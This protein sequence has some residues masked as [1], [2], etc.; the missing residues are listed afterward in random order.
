MQAD[1]YFL[2]LLRYP[3][4]DSK[5]RAMILEGELALP[6]VNWK[7]YFSWKASFEEAE[8]FLQ[9]A[10]GLYVHMFLKSSGDLLTDL[11][12]LHLRRYFGVS[13]NPA[14]R[15]GSTNGCRF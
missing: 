2:R 13:L 6:A 11:P 5:T 9:R 14:D 15:N 12:E 1:V 8:G 4:G 10:L 7:A 3:Q